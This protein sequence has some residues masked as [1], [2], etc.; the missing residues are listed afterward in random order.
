MNVLDAAALVVD[1]YPGG[2][3]ALGP[4]LGKSGGTLAHEL[5]GQGT[6]KLGLLTAVLPRRRS[7]GAQSSAETIAAIGARKLSEGQEGVMQAIRAIRA[8]GYPDATANEIAVRWE[9]QHDGR[10]SNHGA[11]TGR[12]NE[13]VAAKRLVRV[14]DRRKCR[15]TGWLAAPL[16][17]PAEQGSLPL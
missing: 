10:R 14:A 1:E 4:R 8:D 11:I 9:A 16:A 6:A 13:L 2:A 5:H 12:I 17:I 7:A 3:C 15:V